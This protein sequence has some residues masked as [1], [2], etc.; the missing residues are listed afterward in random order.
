MVQSVGVKRF[1]AQT[2][3]AI[4]YVNQETT[5]LCNASMS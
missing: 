3:K 4:T 1:C 5:L 2:A